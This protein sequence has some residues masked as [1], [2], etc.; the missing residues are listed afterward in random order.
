MRLFGKERGSSIRETRF[1]KTDQVR[2]DEFD[3]SIDG[4]MT[5]RASRSCQCC[6]VRSGPVRETSDCRPASLTRPTSG[7]EM[8]CHS[9]PFAVILSAAK[10][11]ALGAPDK[12]HEES[13]PGLLGPVCTTQ[14]KIPRFARNDISWFLGV[15]RLMNMSD[16][17]SVVLQAPASAAPAFITLSAGPW[18]PYVR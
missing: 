13:R 6:C 7:S 15:R 16:C 12:L 11:L 4:Q 9:E 17:C 3:Q 14:N 2:F 10:D 5:L 1:P 18:T 8:R